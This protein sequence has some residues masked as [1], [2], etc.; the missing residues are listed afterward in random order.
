M[1]VNCIFNYGFDIGSR[2]LQ[3]DQAFCTAFWIL[4]DNFAV[5]LGNFTFQTI[6]WPWKSRKLRK[7]KWY[8]FCPYVQDSKTDFKNKILPNLR[9]VKFLKDS[10][11]KSTNMNIARKLFFADLQ[12]ILRDFKHIY[13]EEIDDLSVNSF[14]GRYSDPISYLK[15]VLKTWISR[16]KIALSYF[17]FYRFSWYVYEVAWLGQHFLSRTR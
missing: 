8:F 7:W 10:L 9:P 13:R 4:L 5:L 6:I 11:V 1:L 14:K 15:T 17:R 12:R 2:S 16:Q 3:L